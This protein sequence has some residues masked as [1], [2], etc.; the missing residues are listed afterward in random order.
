MAKKIT[1][2]KLN[3]VKAF[4]RLLTHVNGL[5]GILLAVS[6]GL[7]VVATAF[8]QKRELEKLEA[9]LEKTQIREANAL[10]RKDHATIE[11]KALR[12][13]TAFLEVQARDRLNYYVPGERILRFE[14]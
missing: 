6:A 11:L 1:L 5:L 13:D 9:Q 4:N 12:E 10:A 8:P 3:R 2:K 7:V 14:R